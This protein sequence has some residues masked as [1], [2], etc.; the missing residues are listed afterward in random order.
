MKRRI[1]IICG[2][3]AGAAGACYLLGVL[4]NWRVDPYGV[5]GSRVFSGFN[6]RKT[7]LHKQ[8]RRVKAVRIHDQ[9][10]SQLIL[11]T[12]RA[13]YGLDF[14]HP[15]WGSGTPVFNASIP[16]GNIYEI[17]RFVQHA[18]AVGKLERVVVSL[19]FFAFNA[20]VRTKMGDVDA[21]LAAAP[22]GAAN[23][24]RE[25]RKL[26]YG[27]LF[28]PDAIGAAWKTVRKQDEEARYTVDL[29]VNEK[30]MEERFREGDGHRW[31]FQDSAGDYL[32]VV[33]C[34]P[35]AREYAFRKEQ[36]DAVYDTIECLRNI[37]RI[38]HRE[39][40]DVRLFVTPS[41]AWQL[42][43]IRA[44]G[45][46]HLF[47]EW[48][49]QLVAVNEEEAARAGA[50]PFPLWDFFHCNSIT[51]E[52]VPPAGDRETR[53]AYFLE[54]SHF[55]KQTGRMVLDRLFADSAT[56]Q[57]VP[58]DFGIR[59]TP[60]TIDRHLELAAKAFAAWRETVPED[61][62]ELAELVA[63]AATATRRDQVRISR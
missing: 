43:C 23:G 8:I 12:S 13:E 53:M 55:S 26:K 34:P 58:E 54:G 17:M 3:A 48:K 50:E 27:D 57:P 62:A 61:I 42:E 24:G 25:R 44:R 10:P 15:C 1:A 19:D 22:D 52:P 33:Y 63:K 9:T 41:H 2:L 14:A 38:G 39:G 51:T 5:Y 30:S 40:A 28:S 20:H 4:L 29:H 21:L 47:D 32:F 36:G 49:R 7:E 16:A 31:A 60:D 35:P 11:G 18:A 46:W 59:M 37:L 56:G 6:A 45:I